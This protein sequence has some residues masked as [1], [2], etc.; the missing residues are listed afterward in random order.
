MYRHVHDWSSLVGA[1]VEI[2]REGTSI[3]SGTVDVVTSD[4]QILWLVSPPH[5][6][7]LFEKAEFFQAWAL[8]ESTGFHYKISAG[9]SPQ[10]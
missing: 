4:G 2:R 10:R 7:R 8:E 9:V 1:N 6:R 3:C 5:G